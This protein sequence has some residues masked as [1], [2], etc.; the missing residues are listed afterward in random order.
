MNTTLD[1]QEGNRKNTELRE[2]KS[3]TVQVNNDDMA[4]LLVTTRIVKLVILTLKPRKT[5]GTY[6][7]TV[8]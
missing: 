6:C 2:K 5:C 7:G 8:L 4:L 1:R 3:E